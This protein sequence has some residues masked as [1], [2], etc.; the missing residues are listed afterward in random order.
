MHRAALRKL[1]LDALTHR[2]QKIAMVVHRVIEDSPE[3]V[4][5]QEVHILV[6]QLVADGSVEAQG[7]VDEMRKGEVRLKPNKAKSS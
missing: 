6:T 1:I 2:F 3:E 7:L 4:S 5:E